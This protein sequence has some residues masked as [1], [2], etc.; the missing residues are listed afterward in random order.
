M[1]FGRPRRRTRRARRATRRQPVRL[2]RSCRSRRQTPSASAA[3]TPAVSERGLGCVRRVVLGSPRPR[4]P[5]AVADRSPGRVIGRAR[6]GRLCAR[7]C[8]IR[9]SSTKS[10]IE[11]VRLAYPAGAIFDHERER[12]VF[13]V[14]L[15]ARRAHVRRAAASRP[16]CLHASRGRLKK[17]LSRAFALEQLA[18]TS[19]V[20][21]RRSTTCSSF[22]KAISFSSCCSSSSPEDLPAVGAAPACATRRRAG[23]ETP[24]ASRSSLMNVSDRPR[25]ARK[26][27]GCAM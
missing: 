13:R 7:A 2:A 9:R 26:S 19:R 17:V 23:S 14:R 10:Q 1:P 3:S 22:R 24:R 18:S 21:P 8:G 27:G 16:D 20:G 15:D 25:F 4:P 5:H 11:A 6:P 12:L